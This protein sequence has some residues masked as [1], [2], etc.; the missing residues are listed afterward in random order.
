MAHKLPH[1]YQVP[2]QLP[3]Q[4]LNHSPYNKFMCQLIFIIIGMYV[5]IGINYNQTY[6]LR[7][8]IQS[9][10]CTYKIIRSQNVYYKTLFA[11]INLNTCYIPYIKLAPEWGGVGFDFSYQGFLLIAISTWLEP[12][13]A[14]NFFSQRRTVPTIAQPNLTYVLY[15]V[16]KYIRIIYEI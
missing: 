15:A 7:H 6:N 16:E 4:C 10:V 8:R 1:N 11:K 5:C 12:T 14:H 13:V 3:H 2:H 9:I